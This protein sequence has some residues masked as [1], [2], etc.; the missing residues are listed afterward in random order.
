MSAA[1]ARG[2]ASAELNPAM[3]P[4]L[5]PGYFTYTIPDTGVKFAD[6]P[7]TGGGGGGSA[8]VLN[9]VSAPV[10]VPAEFVATART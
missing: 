10:T 4:L 6:F 1:I 9:G 3:C 8:A 2:M 7:I 5:D